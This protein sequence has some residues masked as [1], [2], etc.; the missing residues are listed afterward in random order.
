MQSVVVPK[1]TVVT[2]KIITFCNRVISAEDS[3]NNLIG[4]LIHYEPQGG[5]TSS[6][7]TAMSASP[8]TDTDLLAAYEA[9]QEVYDEHALL[10]GQE[11]ELDFLGYKGTKAS[12]TYLYSVNENCDA[13]SLSSVSINSDG[14]I[15]ASQTQRAN[16]KWTK[17]SGIYS[18]RF[19][20]DITYSGDSRTVNR[21]FEILYMASANGL[22]DCDGTTTNPVYWNCLFGGFQ[23]SNGYWGSIGNQDSVLQVTK[24]QTS[25]LG[26]YDSTGMTSVKID[27]SSSPM[28]V[29]I[30]G[31]T[32]TTSTASSL[33]VGSRNNTA[34]A[35][36]QMKANS[37]LLVLAY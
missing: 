21:D 25:A 29:T 15:V 1:V 30:N 7:V 26:K 2:Q 33:T 11:P 5:W 10:L 32:A 4:H 13:D 37:P 19:A 3:S 22:L 12:P 17:Y 31:E 24:D 14:L 27:R 6:H 9:T 23:N 35:Y 34:H 28:V 36:M 8:V 18:T 20:P 16:I